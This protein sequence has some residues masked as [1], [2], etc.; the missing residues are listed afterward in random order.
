MSHDLDPDRMPECGLFLRGLC[1]DPDCRYLHVKKAQNAPDCEEFRSS[2]CPAGTRCPKRHYV[3]PASIETK[4]E[5]V[6]DSEEEE[7]EDEVL[8]K[9]WENTPTLKMYF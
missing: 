2:W 8:R 9:T 3:P 4:R 5:R 1:A 7:D 6:D